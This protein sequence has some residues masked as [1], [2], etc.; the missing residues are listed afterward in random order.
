MEMLFDLLYAFVIA[1]VVVVI[2]TIGIAITLGAWY[3][4]WHSKDRTIPDREIAAS[5]LW[6]WS[7]IGIIAFVVLQST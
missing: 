6:L 2:V 5:L 4:V 1:P 3:R 7:L